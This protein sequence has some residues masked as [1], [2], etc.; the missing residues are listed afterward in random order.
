MT[1]PAT[2]GSEAWEA[3]L[4]R[5]VE[6]GAELA[7][8]DPDGSLAFRAPL[9]RHYRVDGEHPV[10]WIRPLAEADPPEHARGRRFGLNSCRRR[11]LPTDRA[12]GDV[13]LVS[14]ELPT[15]QVAEIHPVSPGLRAQL[16]LWDDFVLTVLPGDIEV[17]LEDLTDDSWHG[18]WA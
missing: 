14:F 5:L 9:A 8:T 17:A 13:D 10:L 11:S 2:V 15:G 4:L 6:T 16:E 1:K 18:P 3:V 7:V 12:A